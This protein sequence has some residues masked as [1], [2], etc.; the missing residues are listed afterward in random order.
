ME[1][2]ALARWRSSSAA[3]DIEKI[4]SPEQLSKLNKCIP[5]N[6]V[7][8]L[9]KAM[10]KSAKLGYKV[11]ANIAKEHKWVWSKELAD[12]ILVILKD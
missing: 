11:T 8:G 2:S 10:Y 6:T 4:L 1:S 5:D 7:S 12:K 9:K 3:T